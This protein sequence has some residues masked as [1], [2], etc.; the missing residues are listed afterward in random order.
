MGALEPPNFSWVV[1]GRLAGLAMPRE[2]GHYRY[3]RE[4]GV[5]HLVSLTERAP[6]HHGCCPQIQLHRLRIADFTPPSPE[7]IQSFLQIVE[8]ANG[9]GEAV[10]VHCMLGHG[11]TGTLLACYLCKEQHLAGGDAIREIRRL[12]PG[13]I[14]TSEQEQAVL[15]FCQCLG[16]GKES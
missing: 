14:E 4:R 9:R 6:P 2:P 10:A 12:R 3:L 1:E 16:A 13:S 11:R 8:E 5:R 7:Q 15:R